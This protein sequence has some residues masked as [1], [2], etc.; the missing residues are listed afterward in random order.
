MLP[1][2]SQMHVL[3]SVPALAL[4]AGTSFWFSVKAVRRAAPSL[5]FYSASACARR[6]ICKGKLNLHAPRLPKSYRL[7]AAAT[8]D[9]LKY[10]SLVVVATRAG[11]SLRARV[12]ARARPSVSFCLCLTPGTLPVRI[13]A[14]ALDTELK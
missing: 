7:T 13:L 2:L 10:E 4:Q 5:A 6:K 3:E 11:P 14:S 1:Q 12:S 9:F 8:E